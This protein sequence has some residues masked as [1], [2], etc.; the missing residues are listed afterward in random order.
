MAEV[1]QAGGPHHQ[2]QG[3]GQDA[4]DGGDDQQV[5]DQGQLRNLTSDS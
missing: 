2:V 5:D 3:D 1:E 4:V